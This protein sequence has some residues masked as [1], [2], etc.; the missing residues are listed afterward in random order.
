MQAS[1]TKLQEIIEGNK[2]YVVPLF[3][4]AYSWKKSQWESL[5]NDHIYS[6]IVQIYL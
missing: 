1:E 4:R 5:W 6:F 3:Q 2:Q